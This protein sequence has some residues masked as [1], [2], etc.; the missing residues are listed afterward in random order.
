MASEVRGDLAPPV[1]P[2]EAYDRDY[3]LHDCI[4]ADVWRESEGRDIAGRYQA[5]ARMAPVEPG[6]RVL[7]LGTGRGEF[8][9]AAIERGA[10]E[11]VGVDYSPDAVELANSTLA[12]AGN[13]EGAR[14]LVADARDLPLEAERFD[15]VTM[16]D[17]VE[18]LT[19]AE[20]N[21]SLVEARRVLRPGG[22]IFAHTAPNRLIYVTYWVQRGIAPWRWRRWPADPRNERQ[23]EM[24]VNEQSPGELRRA[25]RRAGFETIEFWLGE[26]VYT[27]F[28]P[29]RRAKRTYHRLARAGPLRQFGVANLFARGVRPDDG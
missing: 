25:L 9:R 21:A 2:A 16:F 5:L 24:H 26:W 3:Y 12:A 20:L 15:L 14:A 29:D 23:H 13:P 6:S 17:M 27:G 19:A 28:V 1:V 22:A 11:A 10:A 4:G 18:H 7:D 8:L